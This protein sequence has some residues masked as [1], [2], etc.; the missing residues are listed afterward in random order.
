MR[1]TPLSF[2]N[3]LL[4]K[5]LRRPPDE[6]LSTIELIGIVV[7]TGIL[8]TLAGFGIA[9][10][11]DDAESSVA[12]S[13]LNTV[14]S[15]IQAIG[16]D[17]LS[18][19]GFSY[20]GT[21]LARTAS[22]PADDEA[23]TNEM[24]TSLRE[25]VTNINFAVMPAGTAGAGLPPAT[26]DTAGGIFANG[27]P[28][29]DPNT[30]YVAVNRA[31]YANGPD[32]LAIPAGHLARVVVRASEETTLCAILVRSTPSAGVGYDSW[33]TKDTGTEALWRA[34][35]L[36]ARDPV[37]SLTEPAS[38]LGGPPIGG[39]DDSAS[40]DIADPG[41]PTLS[42]T[43]TSALVLSTTATTRDQQIF[44]SNYFSTL[45]DPGR[46]AINVDS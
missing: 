39:V 30:V 38:V 16:S 20:S 6:A 10:L 32:S 17:R 8:A 18:T 14:V 9:S 46:A 23:A 41:V 4:K 24:I 13:N 28:S 19:G 35:C 44:I 27:V 22:P 3:R 29:A 15:A 12:E 7:V 42:T 43:G 33:T 2:V 40:P 26:N 31:S 37:G 45:P 36:P 34:L 21:S 1:R 11:I 5:A 25:V